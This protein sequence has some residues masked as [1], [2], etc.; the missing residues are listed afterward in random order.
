MGLFRNI[1][2]K[3]SWIQIIVVNL[4]RSGWSYC[5]LKVLLMGRNAGEYSMNI[6]LPLVPGW[7]GEHKKCGGEIPWV[8]VHN[9]FEMPIKQSHEHR[10]F[11]SAA[12]QHLLFALAILPSDESEPVSLCGMLLSQLRCR[13]CPWPRLCQSDFKVEAGDMEK[14]G[15]TRPMLIWAA[16]VTN[17]S[18]QMSISEPQHLGSK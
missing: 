12:Q 6:S 18:T 3:N 5:I 9:E 16:A 14:K 11:F 7:L 4:E 1:L 13:F 10:S 8:Q 17:S 15:H 2:S